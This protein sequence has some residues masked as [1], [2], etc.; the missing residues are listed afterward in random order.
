MPT[1]WES[2]TKIKEL[3]RSTLSKEIKVD[4]KFFTLKTRIPS[5]KQ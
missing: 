2:F 4:L 5:F 3:N 1:I